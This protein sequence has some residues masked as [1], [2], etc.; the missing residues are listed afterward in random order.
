MN[1]HVKFNDGHKRQG[2]ILQLADAIEGRYRFQF[3]MRAWSCCVAGLCARMFATE[4]D[5]AE[6]E[7]EQFASKWFGLSF[8]DANRMFMP[9]AADLGDKSET[10][11]RSSLSHVAEITPQW[12]ANMLRYY[13]FTGKIDWVASRPQTKTLAD[14]AGRLDTIVTRALPTMRRLTIAMPPQPAAGYWRGEVVSTRFE[15][16]EVEVS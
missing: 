2:E 6:I 10:I 7:I 3:D 9:S 15:T 13:A 16:V 14:L 4:E 8:P 12:A 1:V 5:G 11:G